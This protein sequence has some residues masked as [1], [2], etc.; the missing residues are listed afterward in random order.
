[1]LKA[2]FVE[3]FGQ[4]RGEIAYM[5]PEEARAVLELLATR[6]LSN[7]EII[8]QMEEYKLGRDWIAENLESI[9]GTR[10]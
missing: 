10:R 7:S 8:N 9:R 5:K 6:G 4:P 1:M 3:L 2:D